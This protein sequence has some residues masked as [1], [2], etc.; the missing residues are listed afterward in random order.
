MYSI[1][2]FYGDV[3]CPVR[4]II[5]CWISEM[6]SGSWVIIHEPW[7]DLNQTLIAHQPC[8][9]TLKVKN[10]Q[11]YWDFSISI[12]S[13]CSVR[14]R[15]A[16]KKCKQCK[17]NPLLN[18]NGYTYLW[19]PTRSALQCWWHKSKGLRKPAVWKWAGGSRGILQPVMTY[20][21]MN[22][23]CKSYLSNSPIEQQSP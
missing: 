15:R 21:S 3:T 8:S 13:D 18:N 1:C 6:H 11:K 20:F 12:K 10:G 23:Q 9:R 5:P 19:L 22:P 14:F 4:C 2:A 7:L 16:A 17:C